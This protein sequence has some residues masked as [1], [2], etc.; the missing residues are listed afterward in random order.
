MVLLLVI[1]VWL[2]FSG[3]GGVSVDHLLAR[4]LGQPLTIGARNAA[5]K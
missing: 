5:Q 4:T 1:F 2:V 3:A